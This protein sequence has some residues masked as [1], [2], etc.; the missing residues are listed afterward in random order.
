MKF[1]FLFL[2]GCIFLQL[3]FVHGTDL[4]KYLDEKLRQSRIEL[5]KIHIQ[6][7]SPVQE[8]S[9]N[10]HWSRLWRQY[11]TSEH[12][13]F[14][15]NI[16]NGIFVLDG[17]RVM[18]PS[19]NETPLNETYQ[20]LHE[21]G[22]IAEYSIIKFVKSIV[23]KD[24]TYLLMCYELGSCSFYTIT[25][26][27]LLRFR[28]NI[29]QTGTSVDAVFFAQDDQ[30]YLVIVNNA[31]FSMPS[32][33]YRWYGTY[34]DSVRE[35]MT[36]GA[37]SVTA[38]SDRQSTIIVFVKSDAE[39]PHISSEVYEFKDSNIARIQFLF[40]AQPTSVHHY[41]HGDF[42]F[43][44]MINELGPS[45]VLC[46][47]GRELFNWISLPEIN[48]HSLIN[49]FNMDG[50]TFVIVAHDNIIQLYKSHSTSDW[51]SENIQYL[52]NDQKI[53]DMAVLMNGHVMILI[54]AIRE[55]D[56]YWVEQWEV[57]M[58]WVPSDSAVE[59]AGVT[60]ESLSD[61][62]Q[63]LQARMPAIMEA[64]AS[65]KHFLPFAKNLTISEPM[66]FNSLVLQSGQV[67]KIEIAMEE[68][69]LPP[70]QIEEALDELEHEIQDIETTELSKMEI[71]ITEDMLKTISDKIV[72]DDVYLEELEIDRVNVDFVNDV[73]LRYVNDMQSE[74]IIL[75]EDGQYFPHQMRVKN[76]IVQN[77]EVDSLCGIPFQYWALKSQEEIALAV[78]NS[79]PE[80]SNDTIIV[81]SDLTV[82]RLNIMSLNGTIVD[83]LIS[84][85]FIINH[86]QKIKGTL[87]YENFLQV[88]NLTTPML[89]GVPVDQLM[90]TTTDQSFEDF[91]IK[92]L[93]IKHLHA[94]TI[95]GVPIEE[96]ARKSRKNI[97]KGKLTLANLRVTEDLVIDVNAS[98]IKIP[99][100][101]PLQIYENVT[102]LGDLHVHNI[103]V[104]K[105]AMLFVKD[106][107]VNVSDM[108]DS[109]WTKST[110]QTIT[111][112]TIFERGLTIDK[113]NTKYLNGF[114]ESDFLY[115]TM[116]EIPNEF[117]NLHFENFHVDEFL[118][119][120]DNL[121]LFE[122]QSHGFL[123]QKEVYLQSL[124]ANDILTLAFNGIDVDGIMNGTQVNISRIADF[125]IVR[126]NRVV[127]DKLGVGLLNNREI[128][129]EAGLHIDDDHQLSIL[130]IPEFHVRDL[131]VERL[132]GMDM[133]S[134]VRLKDLMQSDVDKIVIDGDLIVKDLRLIQMDK[135][136]IENFLEKLA[137]S[138]DIMI[139]S[140]KSIK[141]LIVRNIT[142]ES[143][144]GQNLNH[145]FA[146][147]LSKSRNQR[148]P[149]HFS[150]H[151][152]ISDNVTVD[153]ING[154]NTSELIWVNKPI[155]INGNVTF[156]DLF[157]EGDIITSKMN[158]HDVNE[159]YGNLLYVPARNI[160]LL[161]VEKDFNWK[162]PLS[163]PT[164]ISYLLNNAVT[165][166]T[167]QII[168]GNV[169]FTK[170]VHAWAVTGL[171]N[172]INQIQSI[173]SDIVMDCGERIEISGKKFFEEN[174]VADS[175]TVDG[176]V[177]IAKVNDV[178]ILEFN[179]SVVRKN[180][181]DTITGPLTFLKEVTVE[182]LRVNNANLNASIKAAVRIGD[183]MPNNIL[184]KNLVVLHD[185]RLE[186][187]DGINFD[188]FAKNR[189]T[190]N[191]N[192]YIPCDIKFNGVVTV[193][194]NA[195]IGKI[196]R[197]RPS[198]F[199]LNDVNQVQ[200]IYGTKTFKENLIVD[201]DVTAPLVNNV[202]IINEYKNSVQNDEDVEIIGN[203]T[204]KANVRIQNMNVSG[205]VN[206]IDVH[207]A[208]DDLKEKV[209]ETLQN[210]DENWR[211]ID[212]NIEYSTQISKTLPSIF[213]YLEVEEYL[214]IPG[215]NITKVDVVY[216]DNSTRLNMY[217]ELP[218]RFCSLPDECPCVYQS[219]VNLTNNEVRTQ[220]ENFGKIVK[221]FHNSNGNLGIDVIS[222]VVS[223]SKKCIST[224]T[225][226]EFTRI[227]WMESKESE[228]ILTDISEKI[229]GY[230]KDAKMFKHDGDTY[231]VLAIYYDKAHA[232][233]RTNSLLYKMDDAMKNAT[234]IQKLSTN[235]AW[236]L[237]IF[238]IDREVFLLI[239][240]FAE[241]SQSLLYR[242]DPITQ[243]FGEITAFAS[244][245]RYVKN[246]SQ[247]KDHFI[248]LDDPDMHVINIYKYDFISR[249]FYNYQNIFHVHPI[250][251]LECFYT[252]DIDNSDV[253]VIVTTEGGRFYI[254]EYMFAGK[255]Q[256]RMQFIV[257]GLR[258][259]KPFYHMNRHYIFAGT[260]G[261]NTIF[262]IVKQGPQ[263]NSVLSP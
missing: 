249:N 30:L 102:I 37:I 174:F 113:L 23:W 127:V 116:E 126:A 177:S 104:G 245:S 97:I 100:E 5:I 68:D 239:G 254:Y 79:T 176:D 208:V 190:L 226:E 43:V 80:Y 210:L 131:K 63:M 204:F 147:V 85:L 257:D 199:V 181:E 67:E 123:I 87:R 161:K 29:G 35:V 88:K 112:E 156:T 2:G 213:F 167:N 171:F 247:G 241:F 157:V 76:L 233:H 202:N 135:E 125:P 69:I 105:T 21:V 114:E 170:S 120:S 201:G 218:G 89:N 50:D 152:V 166:D 3:F 248:L 228:E 209:N 41:I 83:E 103:K 155:T 98:M 136:P 70:H 124:K 25:Q 121:S 222:N 58:T 235:G 169:T 78:A 221:N 138:N 137:K 173:I 146:S 36:I 229:E 186:N 231:I 163:D 119:E 237:Q 133:N 55:K 46:W 191:G 225:E 154:Q 13:P 256:M 134:L 54:L 60:R 183:V 196:N 189:I 140:E 101:R 62:I 260:Y 162:T 203:L 192:H 31:K 262:R 86:S 92:H 179:D 20:A 52:Q 115:T 81:H 234:L 193:T 7:T 250:N 19:F 94:D 16:F 74:K 227:A 165:N 32:V 219:I 75:Q 44:L 45:S 57:T 34:M 22:Q 159:L 206:D 158:G 130:K 258:M 207:F 72:V 230:L 182:R 263:A 261:N 185:V 220:R 238:K 242:F 96:V 236:S 42:N 223:N 27:G 117:T 128:C 217:S 99:Q 77:L 212:K 64:E 40:T 172:E 65:W 56:V 160:H 211:I 243:K 150:A 195:N 129:F 139:M 39:I 12:Q 6:Q 1:C 82:P 18:A 149:E 180:C 33:I 14:T 187:L 216:Y 118:S 91:Y 66:T 168:T 178:N 197:I 252:A 4:N 153:F 53:V 194:G 109:F 59:D 141:K 184:F 107:P 95:K 164:S 110:N 26:N 38:F 143:L 9:Y 205:L 8:R 200:I 28:H 10:V 215:I 111:G 144:H 246:L 90:T 17:N 93:E 106:V 232:T 15:I 151:I 71:N 48:P 145:F 259:M 47:D 224:R 188:E 108:F 214:S 73:D 51:K 198:E 61:V 84:N 142:L 148:I 11:L 244:R 122:V 251:G 24:T 132:N 49:I 175:L 253:F 240:C 255:F